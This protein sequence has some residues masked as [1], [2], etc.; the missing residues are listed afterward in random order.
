MNYL[1]ALILVLAACGKT[2][3]QKKADAASTVEVNGAS[4]EQTFIS[5]AMIS[6]KITPG[7]SGQT[8]ETLWHYV[9]TMNKGEEAPK[10]CT[11]GEIGPEEDGSYMFIFRDLEPGASYT[12]AICGQ[13]DDKHLTKPFRKSFVVEAKDPIAH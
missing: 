4:I 6:V 5:S 1:L 13:D 11:R 2:V 10:D 12:F 3:E 9:L 7:L 8:N